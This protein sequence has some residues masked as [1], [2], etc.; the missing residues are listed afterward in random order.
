M[1]LRCTVNRVFPVREGSVT[2]HLVSAASGPLSVHFTMTGTP[3]VN[4]QTVDVDFS[5]QS[6]E[7]TAVVGWSPT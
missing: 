6:G 4:G 5:E 3:P 1:I 7:V 2:R